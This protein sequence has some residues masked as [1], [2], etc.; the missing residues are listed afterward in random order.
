M[1]ET[2]V[3]PAATNA[4][5]IV[6]SKLFGPFFQTFMMWLLSHRG[7]QVQI[8]IWPL[9]PNSER[10]DLVIPLSEYGTGIGQVL[11]LLYVLSIQMSRE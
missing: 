11:A 8:S 4:G 7:E 3:S 2:Q 1:T 6:S 10:D 9:D 5:L